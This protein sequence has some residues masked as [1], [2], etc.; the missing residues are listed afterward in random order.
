[1]ARPS[2]RIEDQIADP[3]F[4]ETE[5]D[6][7]KLCVATCRAHTNTSEDVMMFIVGLRTILH[8][9]LALVL[10]EKM[11]PY[12]MDKEWVEKEMDGFK[13]MVDYM[14]EYFTKIG[15]PMYEGKDGKMEIDCKKIQEE[16]DKEDQWDIGKI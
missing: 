9:Y 13:G 2:I 12:E 14:N 8:E 4:C 10:S 3:Y 5:S 1:M 11:K 16:L 6:F 15:M 7:Y